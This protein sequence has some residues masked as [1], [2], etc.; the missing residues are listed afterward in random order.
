MNT[1]MHRFTY[2][3][4]H[5]IKRINE[6]TRL[7]SNNIADIIDLGLAVDIGSERVFN[8]KHW[9]LYSEID[10]D[11]FVAIQDSYTGLIVTVLPLEYHENLAWKIDECNLT[12]AKS[13]IE[14]NDIP[15]MLQELKK[16]LNYEPSKNIHV[17][18]RYLDNDNSVKT[19][20]LFKL[21][22]EKFNYSSENVFIDK[23]FDNNV[24]E[25]SEL[26]GINPFNIFEVLLSYKKEKSP[27]IV[28][29]QA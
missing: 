2:F 10:E 17:K 13:N 28:A 25:L 22:A 27:K 21:P 19:K 8:K 15:S 16:Q 29:W 1:M 20:N 9:L 14:V 6:R 7:T 11:F 18:I 5:A 4:E 26:E 12:E 24:R 3:S 23:R